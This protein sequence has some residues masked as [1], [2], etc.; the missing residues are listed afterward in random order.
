MRRERSLVADAFSKKMRKSF[1]RIGAS[2]RRRKGKGIARWTFPLRFAQRERSRRSP[3]CGRCASSSRLDA[4]R[5]GSHRYHSLAALTGSAA[6]KGNLIGQARLRKNP[7][8]SRIGPARFFEW[9]A[10]APTS[11]RNRIAAERVLQRSQR[12]LASPSILCSMLMGKALK[13][14]NQPG[15]FP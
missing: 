11:G 10:F 5:L 3:P 12:G 1:R 2:L 4:A 8:R 9:S 14:G 13:K 6:R 15:R 7:L